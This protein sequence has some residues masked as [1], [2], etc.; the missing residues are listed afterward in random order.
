MA[1]KRQECP[2]CGDAVLTLKDGSLRKHPCNPLDVV[3]IRIEPEEV[4]PAVPAAGATI[5]KFRIG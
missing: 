1:G 4:T 2:E 5:P 3:E